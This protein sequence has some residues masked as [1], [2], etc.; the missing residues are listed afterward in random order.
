MALGGDETR[1]LAGK[2]YE[3][4]ALMH[5]S[6]THGQNSRGRIHDVWLGTK[7][8]RSDLEKHLQ[9]LVGRG[10]S[11]SGRECYASSHGIHGSMCPGFGNGNKVLAA[12]GVI[13]PRIVDVEQ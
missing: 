3:S 9:H 10:R 1:I 13:D 11:I 2:P 5:A 7:P 8:F 6:R 4:K 12:S